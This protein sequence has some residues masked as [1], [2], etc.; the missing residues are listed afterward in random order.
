MN[1]AI[2]QITGPCNAQDW[3]LHVG[4]CGGCKSDVTYTAVWLCWSEAKTCHNCTPLHFFPFLSHIHPP[5]FFFLSFTEFHVFFFFFFFSLSTYRVQC[6]KNQNKLAVKKHKDCVKKLLRQSVRS[7]SLQFFVHLVHQLF[8]PS[9]SFSFFHVLH[10]NFVKQF[11]PLLDS[12]RQR[13]TTQF[14]ST[15]TQKE[16]CETQ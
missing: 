11:P 2:Y 1:A 10:F 13:R 7:S 14:F 4:H 5:T 15:R 16:P 9:R 8:Y 6:R 12:T 3:R